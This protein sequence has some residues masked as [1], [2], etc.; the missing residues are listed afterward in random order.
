MVI[1]SFRPRDARISKHVFN[2]GAN[3][4]YSDIKES[5]EEGSTL[6][7]DERPTLVRTFA[8][9][10]MLDWRATETL[11]TLPLCHLD[12]VKIHSHSVINL[13]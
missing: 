10:Q 13:K 9:C 4:S 8:D 1:T 5:I 3:S 7:V 6:M 12:Q 11:A 2:R